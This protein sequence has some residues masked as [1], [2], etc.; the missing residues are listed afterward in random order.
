MRESHM[1]LLDEWRD[2]VVRN[3]DR[4]YTAEDGRQFMK[5]LSNTC[6]KC[7]YNKVEFCDKCHDYMAVG[8]PDCWNCHVEPKQEGI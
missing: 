5:S 1:I 3:G 4:L 6:M 2:E 7:H 8:Q